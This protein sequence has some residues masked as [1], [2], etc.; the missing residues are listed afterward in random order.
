MQG[1]ARL[2]RLS[3]DGAWQL[4]DRAV[5]RGLAR[6]P[7]VVPARVGVDEKAAG[8][9][10]DYITVVSNIDTGMV[11]RRADDRRQ[12]SLDSFF[13][14]FSAKERLRIE[15][16]AVDLWDAYINS[17]CAHLESADQRIVFDCYQLMDYLTGAVGTVPKQENRVLAGG[18]KV[19]SGSK[20][21][22]LYS[23]EN[24]PEGHQDRF[25][26][27]RGGDLKTA[28]AWAI[29]QSLRQV[30]SYKRR[31]WGAS[32]SSAGTCKR[33]THASSR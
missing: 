6:K 33:R 30:W 22:W 5:A 12:T 18:D 16:V 13:D 26:T 19:L 3:W 11:E 15:A 10:Q 1:A 17:T 23:A 8:R 24:L 32:T 27:L 4:M 14:K 7:H 29:K 28:R 9:G 21:L 25:A 2:L 20:Y 31:G